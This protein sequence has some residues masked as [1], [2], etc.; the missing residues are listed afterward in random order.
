MKNTN[1]V[2]QCDVCNRKSWF[3]ITVDSVGLLPICNIT[4][5]CPGIMRKVLSRSEVL[6]TPIFTPE[7]QGVVD[8]SQRKVLYNQDFNY[9]LNVWVIQHNLQ[10]IPNIHVYDKSINDSV[11]SSNIIDSSL[12]TIVVIDE[13]TL[14]VTFNDQKMYSG[15]VQCVA[16]SSR[17]TLTKPKVD[18]TII[19][20]PLSNNM[21]EITIAVDNNPPNTIEFIFINNITNINPTVSITY[22]LNGFPSKDSPWYGTSQVFVDG[23]QYRVYSFN[24]LTDV[25]AKQVFENG[26]IDQ[27]A[28]VYANSDSH[29]ELKFLLAKSPFTSNDIIIDQYLDSK[30][31]SSDNIKI[32]Y[33]NG[34]LVFDSVY[35]KDT[36]PPI[37]KIN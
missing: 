2:Y 4:E 36:F 13:D 9:P 29:P 11:S 28:T 17:N 23:K 19:L 15:S 25:N 8:W 10:C 18:S 5:K 24:L 37:Y 33:S 7:I 1:T 3:T 27:G 31:V 6:K 20:S 16:S 30:T 26:L 14:T 32:I 22:I 21:G 35:L 12:Y 34:T